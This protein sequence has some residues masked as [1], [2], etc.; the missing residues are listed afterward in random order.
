MFLPLF[1]PYPCLQLP[2]PTPVSNLL[3]SISLFL[4][5]QTLWTSFSRHET[6]FPYIQSLLSNTFLLM[7]S[8]WKVMSLLGSN[9]CTTTNNTFIGNLLFMPLSYVLYLLVMKIIKRKF[10]SSDNR[11]VSLITNNSLCN[12][13]VDLSF[14]VL[15]IFFYLDSWYLTKL[16]EAKLH[17][18]WPKT[19]YCP[20]PNPLTSFPL[21]PSIF[22]PTTNPIP[23]KCLSPTKYQDR[24]TKGLC[25]NYDNKFHPSHK[26]AQPQ[27]LLLIEEDEPTPLTPLKMM[28]TIVHLSH[29]YLTTPT[30]FHLLVEALNG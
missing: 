28:T 24:C 17:D 2:L 27:L 7:L 9:G 4:T 30:L 22:V 23:I 25:Y 16:I 26:C 1:T 20:S 29:P 14:D 19:T 8:L 6:I 11:A 10:L 13:V 18:T 12:K 21:L 15:L 5:D 3:K